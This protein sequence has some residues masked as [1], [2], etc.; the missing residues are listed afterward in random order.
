MKVLIIS[1]YFYPE[2]E[3][4]ALRMSS[5]A[6]YL[7][8]QNEVSII[9]NKSAS[10]V[11]SPKF[12]IIEL[13]AQSGYVRN[14]L[15]YFSHTFK[16]LLLHSYDICIIS[17]GPF[18]TLFCILA[19]KL[20]KNIPSVI[21]IRDLWYN[22]RIN[23]HPIMKKNLEKYIFKRASHITVVSDEMKHIIEKRYPH[24]KGKISVILNGSECTIARDTTRSST[25]YTI[26]IF[27]KCAYYAPD[28]IESL[29]ISLK[30]IGK[31]F[32]LKHIG[33]KEPLFYE[34]LKKYE[35]PLTC[36]ENLGLI[37][38]HQG[39]KILSTV[40]CGLINADDTPCGY[41]T[42]VFDY[43]CLN[44]PILLL[45]YKNDTELAKFVSQFSNG[46][47]VHDI[48]SIT[49]VLTNWMDNPMLNLSENIKPE[50]YSR[51][52]QNENFSRLLFGLREEK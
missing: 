41:G 39:I 1:P 50:L 38:Y 37:E 32:K 14:A 49:N 6:F 48:Q 51:Q 9:K 45:S 29:I 25:V 44:L 3:V 42:K 12:R 52:F 24:T 26:G 28:N 47:C 18:Y 17:C 16:E 30:K 31:P 5:L 21:D 7:S 2:K 11:H 8:S 34:L 27:G 36:Y 23:T 20:F 13:K 43:I 15:L 40:N 22:E 35:L 46:V 10:K 33:T 19:C 4:G